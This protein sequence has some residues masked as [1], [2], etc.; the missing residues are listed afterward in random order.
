MKYAIKLFKIKNVVYGT[1]KT[2]DLEFIEVLPYRFDEKP[3]N[4]CNQLNAMFK[5]SF[6]HIVVVA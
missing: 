3:V 5:D 1:V 6:D 2:W 4:I